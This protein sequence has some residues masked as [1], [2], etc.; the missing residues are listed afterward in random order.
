MAIK[1]LKK[2]VEAAK[3]EEA[4]KVEE[5]IISVPLIGSKIETASFD[6]MKQVEKEILVNLASR[7][8]STVSQKNVFAHSLALDLH[9]K[10]LLKG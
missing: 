7:P 5:T 8:I 2:T 4:Q 9:K 10:G 6:C 1:S 3:A